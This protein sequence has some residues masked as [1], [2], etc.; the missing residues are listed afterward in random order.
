VATGIQEE[1]SWNAVA[2]AAISG[3]IGGSGSKL[4]V[5]G[6][7]PLSNAVRQGVASAL[8]QG[9]GVATAVQDKFSWAGV[10]AAAMGSYAG[11]RVNVASPFNAVNTAARTIANAAARSL[12]EGSD[13][14]DN[15]L[16]ALPD[17]I[18]Q[19]IGEAIA[20]GIQL[21]ASTTGA[22]NTSKTPQTTKQVEE[23]G[24]MPELTESFVKRLET[25]GP[26]ASRSPWSRSSR[27]TRPARSVH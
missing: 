5:G 18:G 13:F 9:I 27:L 20:G 24:G 6:T 21:G 1:F 19:T 14:G 12:I 3:G 2:L 26:N 4:G 8:G 15:V 17:V 10:A 11:Q 16:A 23:R 22:P 25:D 7:G